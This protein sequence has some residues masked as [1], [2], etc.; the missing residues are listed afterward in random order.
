MFFFFK[1][2]NFFYYHNQCVGTQQ[3]IFWILE[4]KNYMTITLTCNEQFDLAIRRYEHIKAITF[5]SIHQ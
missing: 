2:K 5:S 4:A 3:W 1:D